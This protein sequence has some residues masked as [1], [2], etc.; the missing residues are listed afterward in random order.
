MRKHF[1]ANLWKVAAGNQPPQII[2][3][4]PDETAMKVAYE[5]L[6]KFKRS[7]VIDSEATA[8]VSKAHNTRRKKEVTPRMVY[9]TAVNEHMPRVKSLKPSQ[10]KVYD[11]AVP[12]FQEYFKWENSPESAK[13]ASLQPKQ[14][15]VIMQGGPGSGKT[16]LMNIIVERF[17]IESRLN[18]ALREDTTSIGAPTAAASKMYPTGKQFII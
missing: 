4:S 12:K 1:L 6:T 16:Y 15:R 11:E 9:E 3:S 18:D 10:R 5:K 7:K 8:N 2:I 13:K 17:L 14:Y